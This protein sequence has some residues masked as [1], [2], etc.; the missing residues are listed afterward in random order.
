MGTYLFA[1]IYIYIYI[2]EEFELPLPPP[3]QARGQNFSKGANFAVTGATAL[4][5]DFFKGRGLVSKIWN[6]GSL[7]TELQWFESVKPYLCSTRKGTVI[8][9][10]GNCLVQLVDFS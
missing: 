6:S 2:A 10:F 3:S 5:Y 1:Y 8:Y 4:D 7:S 9:H